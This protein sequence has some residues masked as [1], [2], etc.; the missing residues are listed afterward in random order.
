MQLPPISC[1]AHS[2]S[3]IAGEAS[4]RVKPIANCHCSLQR[5]MNRSSSRDT[6]RKILQPRDKMEK[7]VAIHSLRQ[8]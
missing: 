8:Y 1:Q 7:N 3:Q 2:H 4:V 6:I 5:V